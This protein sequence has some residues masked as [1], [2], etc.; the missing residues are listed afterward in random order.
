MKYSRS[1]IGLLLVA[2]VLIGLACE[3]SKGR[4]EELSV[5]VGAERLLENHGAE[6]LTRNVGLIMNPTARVHGVHVLDTLLAMDIPVKAL[7]AA[8]HGFR[9]DQGAGEVIIDGVDQATGLPVYSLY[10]ATKKPTPG[11]LEGIDLLIFDMQDVGARFYTYNS[12]MKYVLEASADADIEVWILDRP[13]PLGGDYVAGWVLEEEFESFVGMYPI[14]IAHGLTLGELALM[15]VGEGWLDTESTPRL[16]V[17]PMEGWQRSMKWNQTGLKWVA[18][19][20]NLPTFAHAYAYIGTCFIEGT[21][22]SE[23]RGTPNPFLT[24]GGVSTD[25]GEQVEEMF[26][27]WNNGGVVLNPVKFTPESIPGKAINPKGMGKLHT[28]IYLTNPLDIKDPLSVG[29]RLMQWLMQH[30]DL[31]SYKDYLYLLA[32]TKS[33]DQLSQQDFEL[34]TED[35]SVD[36][37]LP[38][39]EFKDKRKTYLLY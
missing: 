37:G 6:L 7:F 32:G 15:A 29:L 24:L 2:F 30:S 5:Q 35:W 14:P 19:S 38:L 28:G 26:M 31:A 27:H 8:E 18:P 12:T 25:F 33:I 11:M 20:P 16:E 4:V 3:P 9:G 39:E 1:S 10:G 21:T 22:L 34:D 17:I 36:W 23:G 13:N